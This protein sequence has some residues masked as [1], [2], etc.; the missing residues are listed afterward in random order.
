MTKV[1][2]FLA[3]KRL[4]SIIIVLV[5]TTLVY[6]NILSNGFVW[7][8]P[9]FYGRWPALYS[10]NN[11][12]ELLGGQLPAQH[13]GIYRPLRGLWQLFIFQLFGGQNQLL[14]TGAIENAFG[15]HLISILI[16]LSA[17][18]AVYLLIDALTKNGVVAFLTSLI[19]GLH[20]IH[21]ET[22]TFFTTSVDVI[23]AIFLLYALYFYLKSNNFQIKHFYLTSV[24]LA[25]LAFFS[26]E[27]TLV[28][29]L[30]LILLDLFKNNF[31]Y[32]IIKNKIK[33]YLPYWAGV[34]VWITVRLSLPIAN[35]SFDAENQIN[36]FSRLLTTTKAFVK[37]IY[38]L[39]IPYP[40][41]VY[42]KIE[43]SQ[44]L[45]EPRVFLSIVLLLGLVIVAMVIAKKNKIIAFSIWWFWL[46][47]AAAANV[48]PTG[49]VM[50]EK[51]SYLASVSAALILA[52]LIYWLVNENKLILKMTGVVLTLL[53]IVAY[54][55]LTYARNF[56]WQSDL[57]LWQ[58]TLKTRPDY[59]RAWNNL[60][61]VYV[62]QKDFDRALEYFNKAKELE[63]GLAITY[64]NLGDVLDKLGN[65]EA[66]IANYQKAIELQ[67]NL[68]ENYNNLGI[69]Y[70]NIGELD[71][72]LTQYQKA[73]KTDPL[74]YLAFSNAGVINLLQKDYDAAK[75][76]FN[77]ALAINPNFGPAHHGLAVSY[78]NLQQLE[79]ALTHY[80]KSIDL[81]P[82][83]IDNYSHLASIYYQQ[84]NVNKTIEILNQG[85]TANPTNIELRTNLGMALANQK[86]YDEAIKEFEE[87]LK[88]DPADERAKRMRSQLQELTQ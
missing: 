1:L 51:Y 30:M 36:L 14:A 24:I 13:E 78:I 27:F 19:F 42:H 41:T 7:D 9:D 28:L 53:I 82:E 38:L 80:Q 39:F 25:W 10:F 40:Q 54:G 26:Y 15:Y 71:Q 67:P 46:A 8:D 55:S 4:A 32:Q 60:G 11:I 64:K 35:R 31:N 68:A 37:Y 87:I 5:L 43:I 3:T 58:Q 16:H 63:P 49:I 56:D 22:I 52:S 33:L 6:S 83:I 86:R 79:P 59:G 72:A 77:Q 2:N 65:P 57:T 21:T 45:I 75:D 66:A 17:V 34:V 84:K 48:F 69:V 73:A 81:S 70:Q 85:I 20:P 62:K 12:G 88:I 74:Y 76:N 23:G 44:T 47:L 29:P 50:A 61:Y 18:L